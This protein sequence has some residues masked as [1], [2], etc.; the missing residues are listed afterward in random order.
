M[1]KLNLYYQTPKHKSQLSRNFKNK[2][3]KTF[4]YNGFGCVTM[5]AALRLSLFQSLLLFFYG[6]RFFSLPSPHSVPSLFTVLPISLFLSSCRRPH[7]LSLFLSP[8]TSYFNR[9]IFFLYIYNERLL[10]G[11][12]A[13]PNNI[14]Y[15]FLTYTWQNF[16]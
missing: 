9:L 10:N 1:P 15:C 13:L 5:M 4:I 2:I 12:V 7:C 16:R 11:V 3:K 8:L 14:T 6:L